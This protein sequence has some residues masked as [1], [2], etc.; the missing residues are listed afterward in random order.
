MYLRVISVRLWL[1]NGGPVVQVL[2]G[3]KSKACGYGFVEPL[4]V[5]IRLLIVC[6][7]GY[8]LDA[9]ETIH[10]CKEFV[11]SPG[12]IFDKYLSRSTGVP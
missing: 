9:K 10:S 8:A 4:G 1:Q 12:S 6:R 3:V 2:S 7:S 5:R 11:G